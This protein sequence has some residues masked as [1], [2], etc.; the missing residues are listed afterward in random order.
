M[1]GIQTGHAMLK[2]SQAF[3][4]YEDFR[5]AVGSPSSDHSCQ[6]IRI[7][8]FVAGHALAPCS[9][10]DAVATASVEIKRIANLGKL[11]EVLRS[12]LLPGASVAVDVLP[13]SFH[14]VL[15]VGRQMQLVLCV[16]IV[17][18]PEKIGIARTHFPHGFRTV[19]LWRFN[20][21]FKYNFVALQREGNPCSRIPTP[22]LECLDINAVGVNVVQAKQFV[23][24]GKDTIDPVAN[25]FCV[26]I[27]AP[28]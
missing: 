14:F 6:R 13:C 18:R 12:A 21:L 26:R 9:R 28:S 27:I 5:Q 17:T 15:I 19:V 1:G 24:D 23:V 2:L 16:G 25:R 20:G 4:D 10:D 8:T 22:R 3:A 11:P 7:Q